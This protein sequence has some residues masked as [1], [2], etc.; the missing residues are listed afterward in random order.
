MLIMLMS[1]HSF[2]Q[3]WL[4]LSASLTWTEFVPFANHQCWHTGC[5][6]VILVWLVIDG[7]EK[8][9]QAFWSQI[10]WNDTG[11]LV[12]II[13]CC[14]L[15]WWR[16]QRN[17][18]ATVS[19]PKFPLNAVKSMKQSY[20]RIDM[21]KSCSDII[22]STY[23]LSKYWMTF[24]IRRGRAVSTCTSSAYTNA[25]TSTSLS[26]NPTKNP[27]P[28]K[29]AGPAV[30]DPYLQTYSKSHGGP[31]LAVPISSALIIKHRKHNQRERLGQ[32]YSDTLHS[33]TTWVIRQEHRN[34]LSSKSGAMAWEKGTCICGFII[35]QLIMH[36]YAYDL[37]YNILYL[38][39]EISQKV[40]QC[41]KR[42]HLGLPDCEYKFNG[43]I[44]SSLQLF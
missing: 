39:T 32:Y 1:T 33:P 10:V 2:Q 42:R 37:I 19:S 27:Q 6:T 38:M 28:Y 9:T 26:E 3:A 34:Q 7:I 23:I 18:H 41:I 15:L 21:V 8:T 24:H 25:V 29:R 40:M 16:S 11:P 30:N 22:D 17:K 12:T 35:I 14:H 36:R 20:L 44:P 5:L 13:A 43:R 4:W 31:A